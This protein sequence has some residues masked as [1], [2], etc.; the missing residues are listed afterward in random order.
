MRVIRCVALLLWCA[1]VG[2]TVAGC[3]LVTDRQYFREGIGPNLYASANINRSNSQDPAN[4]RQDSLTAQDAYVKDVCHAA[5]LADG[6]CDIDQFSQTTWTQF[7]QA[8]MNDIDERCD[9]YLTWLDYI[10]RSRDPTIKQLADMQTASTVIM[11]QTGV[12]AAP[13]AIVAAAVGLAT[14]TFTN[15]TSRLILEIDHS[16]VQAVVL[17]HQKEY[18][19]QLLGTD[20]KPG[21]VIASRP[22]AIYALRSYLRLCMPM[23]IETQINNLV[24]TFSRGGAKALENQSPMISA[25][26]VGKPALVIKDLAKDS[27]YIKLRALLFPNGAKV[28]EPKLKEYVNS[29]F[30]SPTAVDVYLNQ[31][32]YVTMRKRII[33][34]IEKRA[35]DPATACAAGSLSAP[36]ISGSK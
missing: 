6:A 34:C 23:T 11:S 32:K 33:D 24:A 28:I 29:L 36:Q 18:R 22:A 17:S 35:A 21:V 16:T 10:R 3:D 8:G 20:D 14:N 19:E 25:K 15:V 27:T 30:K 31:A 2:L 4:T 26:T 12:G 9:A 13:I 1:S 5:G 7:V